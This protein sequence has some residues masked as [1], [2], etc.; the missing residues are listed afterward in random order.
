MLLSELQRPENQKK[1]SIQIGRGNWSGRGN[2]STRGLKGQKA[3]SGYSR[4]AWFEGGQTPLHMRLP[5]LRGLKKFVK[6][7]NHVV[8]VNLD[9]LEQD[10]RVLSNDV[11]THDYLVGLGYGSENTDFKILANGELSKKLTIQG[12]KTSEKA[13]TLIEKAGGSLSQ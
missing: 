8:P 2:Y 9:I 12:I 5:K 1:K 4:K 11:I 10:G 7:H 6:L 3:R 13:K